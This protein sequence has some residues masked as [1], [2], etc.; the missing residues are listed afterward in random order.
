MC[1][2]NSLLFQVAVSRQYAEYHQKT[3]GYKETN[4]SFVQG[5]MEKLNEA[6]IQNNTIDAVM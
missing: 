4:V 1:Q 3:F 6:G 5:Y 2:L